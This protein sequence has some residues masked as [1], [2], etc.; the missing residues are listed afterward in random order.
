MKEGTARIKINK[1]L[2]AAGWLFFPEGGK[3]AKVQLEKTIKI[4][5]CDLDAHG[6]SGIKIVN[7]L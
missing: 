7:R 3:P 5:Q 6:G 1:L 4:S 2:E